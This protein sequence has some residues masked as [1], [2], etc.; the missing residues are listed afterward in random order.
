LPDGRLA[1]ATTLF[2]LAVA[3]SALLLVIVAG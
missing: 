2:V 1:A 3:I